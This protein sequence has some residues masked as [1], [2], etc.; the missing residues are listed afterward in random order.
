MTTYRELAAQLNG[1]ECELRALRRQYADLTDQYVAL[2]IQVAGYGADYYLRGC[3]SAVWKRA[4]KRWRESYHALEIQQA[5]LEQSLIERA[6]DGK[7][8]FWQGQHEAAKHFREG[9]AK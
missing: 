8:D 6:L 7:D 5:E 9:L 3:W 4:A 1:L 2:Q